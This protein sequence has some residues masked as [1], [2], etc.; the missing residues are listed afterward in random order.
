MA[1]VPT[2]DNSGASWGDVWGAA[3]TP[4]RG[5]NVDGGGGTY[6]SINAPQ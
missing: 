2:V 6:P 4:E 1:Q 5:L 3:E